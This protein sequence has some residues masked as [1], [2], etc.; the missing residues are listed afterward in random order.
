MWLDIYGIYNLKAL[1]CGSLQSEGATK[2]IRV[3]N[4]ID[5]WV[6]MSNFSD[7]RCIMYLK[8][9]VTTKQHDNVQLSVAILLGD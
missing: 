7:Y 4:S 6:L 2:G 9:L 8:V 3:I 5:L 1:G